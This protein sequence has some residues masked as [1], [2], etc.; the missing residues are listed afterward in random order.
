[1]PFDVLNVDQMFSEIV[2]THFSQEV[3]HLQNVLIS[4]IT[5]HLCA[6]KQVN[7]VRFLNT[8]FT[9]FLLTNEQFI[10]FF[11]EFVKLPKSERALAIKM[12]LQQGFHPIMH[13]Y[14]MLMI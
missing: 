7:M 4:I 12:L 3:S 9:I 5:H 2:A 11:R 14:S 10:Y 6:S 1:M 8:G 13:L